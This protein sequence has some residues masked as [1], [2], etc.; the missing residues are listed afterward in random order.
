MNNILV[1]SAH[2]DDDIL[3]C[4]GTLS[5]LARSGSKIRVIFIA[6]GTTCRFNNCEIVSD[7]IKIAIKNREDCARRALSSLDI[8][9]FCFYNLPCGR[10]DQV[11]I[12]EI[13][14]IIENEIMNF[15]PDTIFT[16][17]HKDANSDHRRVIESVI[18]ATRPGAQNLVKRVYSYEI[19][20][21]TE[22]KFIDSF[23]PNYF[24]KLNKSDIDSKITAFKHYSSESR[25]FPFPRCSKGIKTLAN[26]RGMQCGQ[27]YAEAFEIVREIV[28]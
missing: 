14:K 15:Q 13:N 2:P 16:H 27:K 1:I 19:L 8:D 3:G 18:M 7:E 4:G 23:R 24:I 9:D 20:S 6:E 22:W 11:P 17:S 5:K 12:I 25:Q 21:T 10:L 26:M 28:L